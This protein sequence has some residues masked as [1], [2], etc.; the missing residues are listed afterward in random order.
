[1]ID[2]NH[3]ES[4][5]LDMDG[6]LLDLHFDNHFWLEHVPMRYAEHHQVPLAD[7]HRRLSAL[8]DDCIGTLNWYCLDYWT[9]TLGMDVAAFKHEIDHLIQ[10]RPCVIDFLD[11]VRAS[12]RRAVLVTNAH[13]KSLQLKMDRTGL[14]RH[15]DR[16]V[17]SHSLHKAKEEPGF[18]QALA[19]TEPFDPKRTLLVDD[20]LPVLDA[21]RRFGIT[22]LVAVRRPDTRKSPKVVGDYAAIDGFHQIMPTGYVCR[23]R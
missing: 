9:A 17:C 6:T 7:A 14:D 15:L 11:A 10:V 12:G 4:V 19:A 20:S 21:A 3:I 18:W 22:E 2:W 16:M 13:L 23:Q 8:S 1:M 5:F